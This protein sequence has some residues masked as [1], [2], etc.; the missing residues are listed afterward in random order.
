[1]AKNHF[2]LNEPVGRIGEAVGDWK[3]NKFNYERIQGIVV[4]TRYLMYHYTGNPI[5]CKVQLADCIEAVLSK[6]EVP[7]PKATENK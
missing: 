3:S 5:K 1:M 2:G 6:G 4:D 7:P